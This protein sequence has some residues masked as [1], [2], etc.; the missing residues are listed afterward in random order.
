MAGLFPAGLLTAGVLYPLLHEAGHAAVA[1]AVG[2][3][4]VSVEYFPL[5]NVLCD[6]GSVGAAGQ[7]LIGLGG[8]V[9]PVGF[10]VLIAMIFRNRHFWL[11][12]AGVLL[13]GISVMA[14]C[15]GAAAIVMF[16]CGMPLAHE[17][18][19]RVMELWPEGWILCLTAT[20]LMAAAL[21]LD[22][23]NGHPIRICLKYFGG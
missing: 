1:A 17:D 3:R 8:M 2:A 23:R 10:A 20:V 7:V 11:W 21:V 14:A 16:R 4:V 22:L 18:F 12:Y 6:V 5:P 15:I 19:T 13:K 9:A